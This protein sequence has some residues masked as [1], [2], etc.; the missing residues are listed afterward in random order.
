[1]KKIVSG[2]L[3]IIF[4]SCSAIQFQPNNIKWAIDNKIEYNIIEVPQNKWESYV[5]YVKQLGYNSNLIEQHGHH[6][7]VRNPCFLELPPYSPPYTIAVMKGTYVERYHV[8]PWG[9]VHEIRNTFLDHCKN[10]EL[11]HIRELLEK[12]PWHS[13]YPW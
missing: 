11:G 13:K 10:H 8:T 6:L 3:A 7:D 2:L 5:K 4:S 12:L 9:E 1:M